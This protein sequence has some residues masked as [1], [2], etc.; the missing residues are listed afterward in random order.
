MVEL[1]F[2]PGA[3]QDETPVD[4]ASELEALADYAGTGGSYAYR[5]AIDY[6][7]DGVVDDG[8]LARAAQNPVADLISLPFQNNFN[9][10]VGQLGYDQYV[11]NIQ[12]VV[13]F[14]LSDDWNLIT[15]TIV[16][17]VY[18]PAFFS[19]DSHDFGL[20]DVQFTAFFAGAK[21]VGGWILGA[22][23]VI[24]APT[25]TDARLGARKWAAGP[26][27]VALTMR[28][29]WVIGGLFQQVWSF[30]GSGDRS[31][32]EFLAQPFVNYNIPDGN[33]WYLVTAPVIT[34]NWNAANSSDTWTL[35]LGG[36]AGRVFPLG[37]Q[38][39]NIS[40]QA[41]YNAVRPDALGEWGI[42]FQVQLLFPQ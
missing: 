36:G 18:Q 7:G 19:G 3:F 39:V 32:S 38:P 24:R 37:T 29:P 11:L 17:I 8:D 41:Y 23:P 34:A 22:G 14:N 30:A 27:I 20:G 40:L 33:G 6:N 13:P 28:G 26:S 25:A 35:P 15:R 9:F 10:D 12:P 4:E 1:R 2:D 5:A 31:V 21:P 42:R 16:P